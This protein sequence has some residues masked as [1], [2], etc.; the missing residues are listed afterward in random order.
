[1]RIPEEVRRPG[2]DLRTL[3]AALYNRQFAGAKGAFARNVRHGSAAHDYWA[4]AEGRLH[5]SGYKNLKPWDHAAGV[6]IH[7]EAGGYARLLPGARY[8]PVAMGQTGLLSAPSEDVWRRVAAL[9][10]G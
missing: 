2:V 8:D 9:A 5:L 1:V 6:L 7:A 4:L 3:T 10:Q